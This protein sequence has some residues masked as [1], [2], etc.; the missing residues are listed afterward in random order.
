MVEFIRAM[1]DQGH[2]FVFVVTATVLV[3]LTVAAPFVR[4]RLFGTVSESM[5][6]G[7]TSAFN[8][9]V[10]FAAFMLAISL[11]TAE[12]NLSKLQDHVVVEANTLETINRTLR[13]IGD[14]NAEQTRI[15][16]GQYTKFLIEDEWPAMK[17]DGRSAK[18]DAVFVK[19]ITLA[20]AENIESKRTEALQITVFNHLDDVG[21][22]REERLAQT[23][24]SLSALYWDMM[25]AFIV[26]LVGIAALTGCTRADA[27]QTSSIMFA[28]SLFL[29]LII[30]FE[31]PFNGDVAVSP[32]AFERVLP[33]MRISFKK[34]HPIKSAMRSR[35]GVSTAHFA[36]A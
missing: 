17:R 32:K 8:I 31:C 36:A 35:P 15:A 30:T 29:A 23:G 19:L 33:D 22:L 2:L 7:A 16:L 28:V 21:D 26:L 24:L 9:I 11:S 1:Q 4:R 6:A 14:E 27:L 20:E 34:A 5:S 12:G 25:L 3:G 10:T 18:A 13:Q